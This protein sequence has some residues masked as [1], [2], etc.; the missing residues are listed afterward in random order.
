MQQPTID[1]NE[2]PDD[3]EPGAY[4][5]LVYQ[6]KGR[7]ALKAEL[8]EV[9]ERGNAPREYLEAIAAELRAARLPKVAVLVEHCA[10]KCPDGMD[11]R[12]CGY[13]KALPYINDPKYNEMNIAA[14]RRRRQRLIT[15]WRQKREKWLRLAGIDPSSA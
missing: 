1:P 9:V 8:D 15:H 7:K 14:W 3:L 4:L 10:A 5:G 2:L 12:F 6:K 13:T 11:L